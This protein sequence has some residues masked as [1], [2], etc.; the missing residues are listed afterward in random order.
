V[1]IRKTGFNN[2]PGRVKGEDYYQNLEKMER[3]RLA[4]VLND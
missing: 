4:E 1:V 2:F 3:E